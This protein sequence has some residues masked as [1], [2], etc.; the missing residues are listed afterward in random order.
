MSQ[1]APQAAHAPTGRADVLARSLAAPI[2]AGSNPVGSRLPAEAELAAANGL[3]VA[4]VR[5]AL[6]RLEGLGL[7]ARGRDNST[8]VTSGEVRALYRIAADAAGGGYVAETVVVME[9]RR[10]VRADAELA[11]FLDG[12]EGAEWLHLTGLR[13]PADP[14]FGPLSWVDAWLG[15]VAAEVPDTL[16]LTVESLEALLGSAIA[17]VHEDISAAPLTPAQARQ[18]R[19][20]G[21]DGSLQVSRHYFAVDGALLAA[22]RDVHPSGRVSVIVHARRSAA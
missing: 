1:R 3:G 8:L 17:E 21:G 19:A 6:H 5:A 13:R 16:A 12:R 22:V 9:R 15:N 10:V 14:S 4:T 2:L 20:R 18:L 7:I 11:V